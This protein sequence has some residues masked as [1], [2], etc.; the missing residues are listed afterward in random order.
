M[1][2]IKFNLITKGKIVQCYYEII[3]RKKKN[4]SY[5][6]FK[7]LVN[8]SYLSHLCLWATRDV[9]SLCMVKRIKH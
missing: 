2:H 4:N 3:E 7:Y 9:G 5:I 1:I 6:K 8:M